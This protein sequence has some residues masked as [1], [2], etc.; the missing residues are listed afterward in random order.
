MTDPV[1][2][3]D[4]SVGYE[5]FMGRW[6]RAAGGVFLDWLAPADGARWLDVGCGTGAFTELVVR[7][8]APAT[9]DAVDP[10]AAQI[11]HALGRPVAAHAGF[12]VADARALPF[13]DGTFDIVASALA[14]N[15]IPDIA[16]GLREMRRVARA[17]GQVAGYVWDFPAERSP[18]WPIRQ[19]M[20]RIG[21]DPAP[22]PGTAASGLVPLVG[23]FRAA[24]FERVST[25]VI[26][27]GESYA[28][29]ADFWDAQT[30]SFSPTTAIIAALAPADRARLVDAVRAIVPTR[31]D[32]RV[33]YSARANGIQALVPD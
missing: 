7:T 15:F 18:S 24:G 26:D 10:A 22:V 5:R 28:D 32:G 4:D 17:G 9:V 21:L 23:A 33:A 14:L 13:A 20:R 16:A 31:P 19:G 8:C 25:T 30:P 6:S 1:H 11:D 2:R 3:F 27:V 29:F 12:Q